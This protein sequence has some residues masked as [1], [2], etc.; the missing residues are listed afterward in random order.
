MG[1][2]LDLGGAVIDATLPTASP[3]LTKSFSLVEVPTVRLVTPPPM[4]VGAA[5]AEACSPTVP[6]NM[7]TLPA[8]RAGFAMVWWGLLGGVLG[9]ALCWAGRYR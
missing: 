1:G 7:P 5:S 3:H 8:P 2:R 6:A 4:A 9:S